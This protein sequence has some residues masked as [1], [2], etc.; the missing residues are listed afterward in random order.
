MLERLEEA[1]AE[2]QASEDRLRR[3]LAD[4]SH[5]L[6]TPLASIR[7]YAE[8]YRIGA[9]RDPAEAERAMRRIEDEAARMGML[10]EDLLTLARLDE[11][12]DPVRKSVDLAAI[13]RDAVDDARAAAPDRDIELDAA[14]GAARARRPPPAAPGARQPDPQ[15]PRPHAPGHAD[16]GR[17]RARGRRRRAARCATT[18]RACRR[19]T[20]TRCST[21]SG[22]PR[23]AASAAGRA[24]ASAWRSSPAIVEAHGGSVLAANASG[25]G[26]RFTVRLP[27]AAGVPAPVS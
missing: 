10:V 24:P 15:R 13:A 12:R 4:A 14:P 18:V 9:A 11:V 26:A 23:A 3:F 2:R 19:P 25:G 7:G 1:F 5:E 8:L 16:R 22:A 6:R 20:P 17:R 21:A 27:A